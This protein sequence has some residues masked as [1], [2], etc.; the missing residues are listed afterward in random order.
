MGNIKVGAGV[1]IFKK[2]KFLM[3]LRK[4]A[5]GGGTW[6]VP[7][8][9]VEFGETFEETA[10]REVEEETGLKIKNLRF[11]AVT[12]TMFSEEHRQ[13]VTIWMLSDYDSGQP[14]IIEPEKCEKMEWRDFNS[15]PTPLFAPWDQLLSSKFLDDIKNQV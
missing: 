9:H 1:F 11:G 7:G 3:L 14:V 12:T 5:H 10:V 4:G 2:G 15:L 13:S 6:S 8:G